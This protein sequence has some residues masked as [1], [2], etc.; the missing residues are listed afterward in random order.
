MTNDPTMTPDD[1]MCRIDALLSHVWMVRT[2]L[3]HSE[4]AEGDDEL[5]EIYRE[6]YDCMHA[7]GGPW[8]QQDAV[9][10]LRTARKKFSKLR[11]TADEFAKLQ[12]EVSVHTNFQ[13]A[14]TS[15]SHAVREIGHVLDTVV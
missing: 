15:L 2:F 6:L 8:K 14:A 10:Y 9:A 1:A 5:N 13:M 12:P 11:R 7:L 3:K 4:E